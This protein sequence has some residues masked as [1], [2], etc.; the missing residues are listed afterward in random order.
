MY[1]IHAYNYTCIHVHIH[2]QVFTYTYTVLQVV[3]TN[4]P[5]STSEYNRTYTVQYLNNMDNCPPVKYLNLPI[6][7]L[8]EYTKK[9]IQTNKVALNLV[10]VIC[11]WIGTPV[12]V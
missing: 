7:Q 3:L 12:N 5:R 9:S 8:S 4:D 2:V 11:I 6:E 10:C 1:H